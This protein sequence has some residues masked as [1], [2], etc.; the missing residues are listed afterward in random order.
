MI[1]L[2]SRKILLLPLTLIFFFW[3][4]ARVSYF[5]EDNLSWM[6]AQTHETFDLIIRDP[7]WGVLTR[8]KV[9]R[10]VDISSQAGMRTNVLLS[11]SHM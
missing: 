10:M 6:K 9:N 7:P 4:R 11:T 2:I 1:L 8:T 5:T 3:F